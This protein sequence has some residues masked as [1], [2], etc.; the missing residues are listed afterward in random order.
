MKS[1]AVILVT[2]DGSNEEQ[3]FIFYLTW[4]PL[5]AMLLLLSAESS[6][7]S[8]PVDDIRDAILESFR[9]PD[10]GSVNPPPLGGG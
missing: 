9:V 3:K 5:T 10:R 4:V 2:I 8:N 7:Q 6:A 1:P